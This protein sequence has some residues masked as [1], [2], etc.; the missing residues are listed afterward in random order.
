MCECA[1]EGQCDCHQSE[2]DRETK[3]RGKEE[4]SAKQTNRG[5]MVRLGP[6]RE[7]LRDASR[8]SAPPSARR[9]TAAP[10]PLLGK[11]QPFPSPQQSRKNGVKRTRKTAAFMVRP[12]Q[13]RGLTPLPD[14]LAPPL[15]PADSLCQ[16]TSP[17]HAM[18]SN[19]SSTSRLQRCCRKI[20]ANHFVDL[21]LIRPAN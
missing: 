9:R 1:R 12:R 2:R 4:S 8:R 14:I 13:Y 18:H 6:Q 3:R 15:S 5:K 16:V 17:C 21:I 11:R 20:I 19:L 7:L 10:L